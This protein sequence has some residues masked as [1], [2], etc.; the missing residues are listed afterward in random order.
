MKKIVLLLAFAIF[1]FAEIGTQ[2]YNIGLGHDGVFGSYALGDTF[3]LSLAYAPTHRSMTLNGA[4]VKGTKILK[5][6]THW[7]FYT[8]ATARTHSNYSYN[9]CG[10]GYGFGDGWSDGY[11]HGSRSNRVFAD[12]QPVL[13]SANVP[14]DL[15]TLCGAEERAYTAGIGAGLEMDILGFLYEE[16]SD[17]GTASL[18]SL[19][20]FSEIGLG[21]TLGYGD[22]LIGSAGLK[23]YLD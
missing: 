9:G 14:T 4:A 8:Y 2:K 13:I 18:P 21:Y 6:A 1:S 12:A 11:N 10:R 19:A 3:Y 22:H 20:F 16:F 5:Q 17:K 23:Y 7:N 15:T